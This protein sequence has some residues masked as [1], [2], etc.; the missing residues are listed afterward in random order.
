MKHREENKKE[1]QK[2]SSRL[3]LTI[4]LTL[5]L[6]GVIIAALLL[7]GT[8]ILCLYRVGVLD[9]FVARTLDS[10]PP[11]ERF[12]HGIPF[13]GG[14]VQIFALSTLLALALSWFFG[15]LALNPL[16]KVIDAT[17]RVAA[18]DFSVRVQL[19]GVGELQDLSR[20]FNKMAQE[21]SSIETLRSD[22]VNDFSHEF[23]TP[24]VSVQGFAE[25]L[26]DGGLSE[27]EQKEYIA[28]IIA[29]SRRLAAL[30]TNILR[31]SKYENMEI[32]AEKTN[33]A[34]DEQIRRVIALME[35]KWAEKGLS[36]QVEMEE[37]VRFEGNEDL[38]QQIWL[39]LLDNAIK[40][41]P[42]GSTVQ[43]GLAREGG[44][45][46]FSICDEGPGMDETAQAHIF[47][48]F[49]QGD[50]SRAAAGSGLGLAIVKRIAELHSGKVEVRSEPGQG[51]T[52]AVIF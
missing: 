50:A 12:A 6:F 30:S 42:P 3:G 47:E 19:K 15:R 28:I 27:A 31:L 26:Q 52:F 33:L 44:R 13:L 22:F 16:R 21:L 41:S 39:N 34:L 32:V 5:F 51:S 35:P 11:A 37:D 8:V 25:L 18:G 7:I 48:K 9:T 2:L 14:L 10:K 36:L 20:S 1:K 24:I 29:E 4:S 43:I 45:I 23:K 17:R 49:F 40:F 38:I 46:R